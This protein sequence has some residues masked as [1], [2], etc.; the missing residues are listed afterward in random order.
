MAVDFAFFYILMIFTLLFNTEYSL[1]V[2]FMHF[3]ALY[4]KKN[5]TGQYIQGHTV[6]Y[7]CMSEN[8]LSLVLEN[9]LL[10]MLSSFEAVSIRIS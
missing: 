8:A 10:K 1:G 6:H 4:F 5:I 2:Y 7:R 9:I 3:V